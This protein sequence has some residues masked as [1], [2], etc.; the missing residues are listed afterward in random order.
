MKKV[1][2]TL[3]LI[4]IILVV[5][6]IWSNS[7]RSIPNSLEQSEGIKTIVENFL[8]KHGYEE[9]V[10][11]NYWTIDNFRKLAHFIEYCGLSMLITSYIVLFI[12]KTK[13][14]LLVAMIIPLAAIDEIIQIFS[15]RG[16]SIRDVGIDCLG[17]LFGFVVVMV[18][19]HAWKS[20]KFYIEKN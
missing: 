3:L 7:M 11:S 1:T 14:Y 19:L 12:N 20:V 8:I 13:N 10:K 15:K 9:L 2:K 5:A 17:G 18:I 16:P 6:Y 4:T